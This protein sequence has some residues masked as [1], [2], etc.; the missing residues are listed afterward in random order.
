MNCQLLLTLVLIFSL[1]VFFQS[2]S[3]EG[4]V[5]PEGPAG[6]AG[7]Q[8]TPGAQGATGTQGATGAKGDQGNANVISNTVTL[9]NANYQ[10]NYWTITTG[11][12][13]SLGVGAKYASVSVTA[14]TT[15]IFNTGTV[16]V[17]LKVPNGLTSDL[18]AWSLLPF[19]LKSF[20]G[21]YFISLKCNYEIGKLNIYY[22]YEQTNSAATIPYIFSAIVPDYTFKYI[23]IAGITGRYMK[24]P[25]DYND[26]SAVCKYYG[27]PE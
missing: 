8:G 16:L 22:L 5:G 25:V 23:V 19:S 17:Y 10:N 1:S 26:Y 2:C 15:A 6:V 24:P 21:S 27:I 12:S 18:T 20:D 14:I 7:P 9:T 4:P 11:S 3:K 13:S